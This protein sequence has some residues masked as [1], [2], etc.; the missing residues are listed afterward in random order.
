[1]NLGAKGGCH[2]V[3]DCGRWDTSD[4]LG[5]QRYHGVSRETQTT[6][7]PRAN[8]QCSSAL[9][10]GAI[11]QEP[12]LGNP[13][14]PLLEGFVGPTVRAAVR[15]VGTMRTKRAPGHWSIWP[16]LSMS[17]AVN[18]CHSCLKCTCPPLLPQ[19]P[20]S[21]DSPCWSPGAKRILKAARWVVFRTSRPE[22]GGGAAE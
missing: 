16:S 10:M 14:P 8:P 5:N 21:P 4:P 22:T 3:R 13:L 18:P 9:P 12:A 7:V 6:G 19:C 15:S 17:S 1:M 2:S 11:R 20:P